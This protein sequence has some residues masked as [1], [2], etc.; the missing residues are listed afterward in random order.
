MRV[1]ETAV[2]AD[3]IAAYG[4]ELTEAELAEVSGGC[5]CQDSDCD[6]H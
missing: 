2:E 5:W 4:E 6:L 3:D 1:Q